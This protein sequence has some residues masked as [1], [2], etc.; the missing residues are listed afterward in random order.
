MQALIVV[1]EQAT[2][3]H[4]GMGRDCPRSERVG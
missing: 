1:G 2:G 3:P 4:A